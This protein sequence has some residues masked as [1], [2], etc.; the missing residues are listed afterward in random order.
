MPSRSE[1]S[2]IDDDDSRARSAQDAVLRPGGKTDRTRLRLVAAIREEY[3][4]SGAFTADLVA[5]RAGSS[6][7]TFYNHFASKEEALNA[8][9]SAAMNDLVD[10]VTSQLQ[11]ERVLDVG[12]NRFASEWVLA[13]VGFFRTNSVVFSAAQMQFP[14][15][16]RLREVYRDRE[17]AAFEKYQRFVR[18]GQAAHTIRTGDASEIANVMMIVSQGYNNPAILRMNPDDGLHVQLTR[19]VVKMLAPEH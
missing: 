8:A 19:V 1:N 7:A 9:F 6:Q 14:G 3:A 4:A 12:L 18:L 15:S 11:I 5:R 13:C 16:A 2:T 10:M 17:L